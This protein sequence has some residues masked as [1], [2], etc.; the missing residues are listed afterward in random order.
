ME[1][2]CN[3]AICRQRSPFDDWQSDGQESMDALFEKALQDLAAAQQ[4]RLD[5]V[6]DLAKGKTAVVNK[7]LLQDITLD[8]I[9]ARFT[10]LTPKEILLFSGKG[11]MATRREI[12]E[13]L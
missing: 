8:S 7:K 1:E 9:G 10:R 13:L 2:K 12:Q 4:K 3:C 11:R 5:E 6:A